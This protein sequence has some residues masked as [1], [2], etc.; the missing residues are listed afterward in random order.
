MTPPGAPEEDAA[1][2]RAALSLARRGL[3]LTWP[4][5]SVTPDAVPA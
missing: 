2:M 5:P 4:N 1:R 3:G